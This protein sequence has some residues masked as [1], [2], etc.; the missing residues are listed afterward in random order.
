MRRRSKFRAAPESEARLNELGESGKIKLVTPF[1]L[2][3]LQGE[4]GQLT[5][6]EFESLE[7]EKRALRADVLL[8]FFLG[9]HEL[10]SHQ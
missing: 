10:R 1:Q 5:H 3:G 8:L 9:I 4:D 7:G 2:F 6:I